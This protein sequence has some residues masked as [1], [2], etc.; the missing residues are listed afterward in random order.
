MKVIRA[1]IAVAVS[2]AVALSVA[3][4]SV[5]ADECDAE[6]T[7]D[8]PLF[9]RMPNYCLTGTEEKEFDAFQVFDGTKV[10]T[11][12]GRVQVNF[13][14]VK[15][16][17]TAA[18][19]LQIRRNYENALKKMGAAFVYSGVMPESFEDTRSAAE[20]TVGRVARGGGTVWLEAFPWNDGNDYSLSVVQIEAMKQDVTAGELL[21]TLE[22]EGRVALYIN[23]DTG[24]ASIKPESQAVIDQV[25]EM[26]KGSPGLRLAVEG[27]TDNVGSAAANQTLSANRAQAVAAA[28]AAKGVEAGRLTTAGWGQERPIADNATAEGRAK[29]RRVELVKR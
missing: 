10:V 28:L 3:S 29:N 4:G 15:D 20:L 7:K 6:G 19:S 25:A 27:H 16:G 8:S 13:Y 12:E 24:K 22:A 23:F 17:A 26:L 18:S 5:R 14:A 21:K 11:I 9:S 1:S 2:L